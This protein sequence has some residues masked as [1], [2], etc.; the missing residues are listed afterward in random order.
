MIG[1]EGKFEAAFGYFETRMKLHTQ[2]GHWAAFWLQSPT[3]GRVGDPKENGTEIDIFEI[4]GKQRDT[5]LSNLHWNGY[6]K[7]HQTAG[8]RYVDK[9]L[10]DGFHVVGLEWTP[11]EY[12]IFLDGK[13][14]WRTN[15]GISH[16]KEYLILSL[17]VDTWGGDI[18]KAVLPDSVLFDYVRVYQKKA[19]RE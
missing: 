7:E 6:G 8:S 19:G 16:V 13:E 14:I 2:E 17:E 4:L 3:M 12:V 18:S 10:P 11:Q 5:L 9:S 15:K 1:T